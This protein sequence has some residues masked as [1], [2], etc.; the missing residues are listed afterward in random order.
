MRFLGTLGISALRYS[1]INFLRNAVKHID[2]VVL[3]RPKHIKVQNTLTHVVLIASD[4]DIHNAVPLV[5]QKRRVVLGVI[6]MEVPVPDMIDD[7]VGLL[8]KIGF[9]LDRQ[10]RDV[11]FAEDVDGEN[12]DVVCD[13]IGH[14]DTGLREMVFDFIQAFC[15]TR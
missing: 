4:A 11:L 9:S 6:G 14:L 12:V 10:V 13:L 8:Q 3:L 5:F 15:H 7:S 2:Q 1:A